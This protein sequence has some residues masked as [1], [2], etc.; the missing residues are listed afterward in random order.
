VL[1]SAGNAQFGVPRP[2]FFGTDGRFSFEGEPQ[3]F[4]IPHLRNLYQ[5]VGK[6]GMPLA[7]LFLP[8]SFTGGDNAFVGDQIRGFGFLHDGSVDTINRFH[9]TVLFLQRPPGVFGPP[10]PGNPGGFPLT[11]QG[12]VQRRQVEQFMLAF[13]SNLAPIVGQQVTLTARNQV[14]A[15]PRLKLF[16]ERAAQGECDLVA[17]SKEGGYLYQSPGVFRPDERK[18]PLVSET[19]LINLSFQDEGEITFTCVPPGSG[20]RIGIDRDE[21][22]VLDGDKR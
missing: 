16:M 13:D 7:P 4:K 22:G 10:D 2:G 6:F 12:F 9:S 8:E 11:P 3:I 20:V 1:N 17:K 5:K 21:D 14:A 19:Q 18:A 15:L